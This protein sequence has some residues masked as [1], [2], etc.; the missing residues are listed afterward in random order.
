M[1]GTWPLSS[2]IHSPL[3]H[4]FMHLFI[5][6]HFHICL[7]HIELKCIVYRWYVFSDT[8]FSNSNIIFLTNFVR[9]SQLWPRYPRSFVHSV[10]QLSVH[11]FKSVKFVVFSSSYFTSF[12]ITLILFVLFFHFSFQSWNSSMSNTLPTKQILLKIPFFWYVSRF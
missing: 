4:Y 8:Y 6:L 3:V 5:H 1:S 9:Y 11:N 12:R 7:G 2:S 10:F